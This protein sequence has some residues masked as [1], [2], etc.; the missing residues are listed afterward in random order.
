MQYSICSV[1]RK[2]WCE[3]LNTVISPY[4]YEVTGNCSYI[5][6]L[7]MLLH[8]DTSFPSSDAAS[9]F[10]NTCK[11]VYLAAFECIP[12]VCWRG[13]IVTG[14][15]EKNLPWTSLKAWLKGPKWSLTPTCCTEPALGNSATRELF[16]EGYVPMLV[17]DLCSCIR[18][19]T[20]ICFLRAEEE[21]LQEERVPSFGVVFSSV[22]F[23]P[24]FELH[25]KL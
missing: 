15:K 25:P 22:F 2:G 24:E 9:L 11:W 14:R 20:S 4:L 21:P 1:L 10:S 16:A 7:V 18:R 17:P 12:L 3:L 19:I 8:W 23:Q 13:C 5:F 6:Q